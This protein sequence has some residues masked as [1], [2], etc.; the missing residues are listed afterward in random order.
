MPVVT[1]DRDYAGISA[2]MLD[3]YGGG[4][5]ATQHLIDL[6]HRRIACITGP[7]TFSLSSDRVRG[8]RDA[9]AAA[10][11]PEDEALIFGG[12]YAYASGHEAALAFMRL[13]DP[14]TAIFACN[15][16]MAIGA[17][18]AL[19]GLSL[20]VPESLS[21]IGYDNI[22]AAAYACPPLTTVATPIREL[23]EQLCQLLLD[24]IDAPQEEEAR[25][26]VMRSELIVRQSTGLAPQSS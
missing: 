20:A 17:I 7:E 1:F 6:H 10:G 23:G 12:D 9:L 26:A 24:S 2:I 14:P 19:R 15:D 22:I 25:R 11:L 21:V 3:N 5:I 16:V 8:Y 4:K 18:S 13:P